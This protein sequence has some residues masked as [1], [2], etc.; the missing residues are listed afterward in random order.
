MILL[1]RNV[2]ELALRMQKVHFNMKTESHPSPLQM[3]MFIDVTASMMKYLVA[4]G[5]EKVGDSIASQIT[6]ECFKVSKSMLR[7]TEVISP[8]EIRQA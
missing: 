8:S 1:A 7:I 6:C 2:A 5:P 3:D 4:L